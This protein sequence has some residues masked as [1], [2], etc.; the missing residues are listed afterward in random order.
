MI[1]IYFDS[2]PKPFQQEELCE[3]L[4]TSSIQFGIR[5]DLVLSHRRVEVS[6]RL[7]DRGGVNYRC[8][9]CFPRLHPHP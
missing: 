4:S 6:A 2:S 5:R 8:R 3:Y 9:A 7:S 1:V